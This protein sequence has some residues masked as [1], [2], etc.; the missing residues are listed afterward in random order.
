MHIAQPHKLKMPIIFASSYSLHY[1]IKWALYSHADYSHDLKYHQ[2]ISVVNSI[3]DQFPTQVTK[4]TLNFVSWY[5]FNVYSLP[6]IS[7]YQLLP[8]TWRAWP[9][10]CL[11]TCCFIS[12]LFITFPIYLCGLWFIPRKSLLIL[13]PT[14]RIY[15]NLMLHS[16]FNSYIALPCI[17][18]ICFYLIPNI[19]L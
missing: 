14:L 15:Y 7:E 8:N 10:F 11:S 2:A 12:L 4:L 19:G 6:V 1:Q 18:V 5:F 16:V 3:M 13:S 9:S 17:I